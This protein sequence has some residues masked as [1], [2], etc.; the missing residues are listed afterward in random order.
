MKGELQ[1][2]KNSESQWQELTMIEYP[3][4]KNE[5]AALMLEK[6]NEMEENLYL[7][8]WYLHRKVA[9]VIFEVF[10]ENNKNMVFNL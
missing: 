10:I 5:I 8:N 6:I 1:N 2:L 3:R 9:I 7:A 4:K